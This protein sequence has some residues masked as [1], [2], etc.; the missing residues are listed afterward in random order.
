MMGA[1]AVSSA[2]A[3]GEWICVVFMA[4]SSHQDKIKPDMDLS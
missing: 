2:S 3:H 1:K 4:L